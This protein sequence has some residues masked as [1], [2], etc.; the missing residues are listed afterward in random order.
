MFVCG[1]AG[2]RN[3][4]SRLHLQNIFFFPI[5]Q[6]LVPCHTLHRHN[7][8]GSLILHLLPTAPAQLHWRHLIFNYLLLL[9]YFLNQL[10]HFNP[11]S[12]FFL[13]Y[14]PF[15][16]LIMMPS[17]HTGTQNPKSGK[18]NSSCSNIWYVFWS[19]FLFFWSLFIRKRKQRGL[20]Q[21]KMRG[22]GK[23][24]SKIMTFHAILACHYRTS[25][26]VILGTSSPPYAT[27]Q[28]LWIRTLRWL[29]SP[30]ASFHFNLMQSFPH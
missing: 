21:E 11:T 23:E 19:W 16:S 24:K 14:S 15:F 17:S 10:R 12:F 3:H 18:G 20:E 25:N 1:K 26:F 2:A 13:S 27:E 30:L 4:L 29:S 28:S 9:I 6:S 8:L 7:G 22:W 5:T